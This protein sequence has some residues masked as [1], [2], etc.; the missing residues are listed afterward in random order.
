MGGFFSS[1]ESNSSVQ[2]E[3]EMGA[4]ESKASAMAPRLNRLNANVEAG[5]GNYRNSSTATAPRIPAINANVEAGPVGNRSRNNRNNRNRRNNRNAAVNVNR[6]HEVIEQV[7]PQANA[8]EGFV[9]N[10]QAGGRRRKGSRK[11]S[12]RRGHRSRRR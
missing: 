12:R 11:A 10:N 8:G 9:G 7:P 2:I 5:R 6:L 3:N 1:P 4:S